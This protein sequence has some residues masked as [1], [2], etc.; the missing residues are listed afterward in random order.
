M[1][2]QG[3]DILTFETRRVGQRLISISA[4]VILVFGYNVNLEDLSL[5]GLKLPAHFFDVT[6]LLILVFS[7]L[8]YVFSWWTD[9]MIFRK[10]YQ[11]SSI[12]SQFQT[13][14]EMD[15][16]FYSGGVE[17]LLELYRKKEG[18]VSEGG[19]SDK[20]KTAFNEFKMNVELW[21]V[22]LEAHQR[23]FSVVSFFAKLYIFVL[24]GLLPVLFFMSATLLLIFQGNLSLPNF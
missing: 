18:L 8:T 13:T 3:Q 12:L 24:W 9:V 21:C 11:K 15:G 14:M 17:L 19:D 23:D 6:A 5:L 4:I 2:I 10:W 1:K 20:E 22:K 7:S 16:T